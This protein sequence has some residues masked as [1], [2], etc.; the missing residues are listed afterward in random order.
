MELSIICP[1]CST[2]FKSEDKSCHKSECNY[3]L[4]LENQFFL[5]DENM[6]SFYNAVGLLKDK[7][8]LDSWELLKNKFFLYPFIKEYIELGFYLSIAFG[9]YDFSKKFLSILKKI[10]QKGEY[11]KNKKILKDNIMLNNNIINET[12]L[13]DNSL[14][15]DQLSISHLY[16]LFLKADIDERSNIIKLINKIDPFVGDRLAIG[17]HQDS[18]KSNSI[19]I[20]QTVVAIIS[21]ATVFVMFFMHWGYE[22]NKLLYLL[23]GIFSVIS[24]EEYFRN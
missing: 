2:L 10:T 5:Y 13:K 4:N 12:Y 19:G 17:Q 22:E 7:R 16:L 23:I 11:Q 20:K 3:S 21:I 1:K 6:K 8:L 15:N 24:I 18:L 14:D 9:E